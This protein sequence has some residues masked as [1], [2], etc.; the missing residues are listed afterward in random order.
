MPDLTPPGL[1]YE[2]VMLQYGPQRLPTK[3]RTG[4]QTGEILTPD[5][6]AVLEY[7]RHLEAERDALRAEPDAA[8]APEPAAGEVCAPQPAGRRRGAR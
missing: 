7:V 5:E 8:A 6:I 3:F 1:P 2:V 4:L